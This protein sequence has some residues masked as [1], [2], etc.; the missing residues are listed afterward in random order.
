MDK[1]YASGVALAYKLHDTFCI[2]MSGKG[3]IADLHA[4]INDSERIGLDRFLA[5][6]YFGADGPS[7]T[8]AWHDDHIP[9]IGCPALEYF[10]R[11]ANMK[12]AGGVAKRTI[13]AWIVNEAAVPGCNVL[14]VK[15]VS[16]E[17]V[18]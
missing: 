16:A 10:E 17:K 14:E 4:D 7:Y 18:D 2:G 1:H 9:W 12:H 15:H 11:R 8:I 13:G 3:E 6:K 5:G